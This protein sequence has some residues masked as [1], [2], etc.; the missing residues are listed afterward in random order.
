MKL[1][2]LALA[3]LVS[4]PAFALDTTARIHEGDWELGGSTSIYRSSHFTSFSL[5]TN[6]QL[7]VMDALSVGL[8]VSY[9]TSRSYT[10]RS[11]GPVATYYFLVKDK[12][13]PF[14]SAAPYSWT[15]ATFGPSYYTGRGS[16]GVK[17]FLT[18]SV[19]FGP[20]AVLYQMWGTNGRRSHTSGALQGTFAIHL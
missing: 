4:A 10:S 1:F 7:F 14:V 8:E 3:L 19:A 17:Y 13:A 20:E 9:Y 5:T 16:V 12:I 6:A 15:K 18:D 2:A 11:L